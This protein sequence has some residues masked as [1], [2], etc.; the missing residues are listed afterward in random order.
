VLSKGKDFSF[1]DVELISKHIDMKWKSSVRP[2]IICLWDK[3]SE[4]YNLGNIEL[5]PLTSNYPGTWARFELYSPEMEKYRPFLYID[6]DTAIIKS[7]ENIFDLVQD[8]SQFI[9]LEDFWQKGKLATGLAWIPANNKKISD[10][11]ES[12]ISY[13]SG[14]RMDYFLRK[15]VKPDLFWQQL[16]DTIV[17]FKP[18][19]GDVV[20]NLP[21]NT[22]LVCFHGKPRIFS[23]AEDILWVKKYVNSKFEGILRHFNVSVIIPYNIDRGFLKHAINSVRKDIQLLVSKGDGNWPQNFNKVLDQATGDYIKYLHEDDMLTDN[24]IEDSVNAIES[25]GV[26]FI[27][28]EAIEIYENSQSQKVWRSPD[29]YPTV[30]SLLKRNNIHSATLMYRREVFD[31][32]GSFNETKSIYALEEYE[33]NLRCLKAGLKIGYIPKVLAYYR[34]HPLQITRTV[35]K[36]EKRSNRNQLMQMYQ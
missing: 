35:N 31:M 26:D 2:R 22:N 30:A 9:T 6:L 34:R 3:A 25:Q 32:V 27:H 20:D 1:R 5:I 14:K 15:V 13:E 33:F 36:F 17:D 12:R 24:C 11:W 10:I 29:P 7:L 21:A 8:E 4:H 16:T 23:A 19:A 18:M 28:G